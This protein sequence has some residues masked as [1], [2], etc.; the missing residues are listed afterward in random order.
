MY[1][2]SGFGIP[3]PAQSHVTDAL[4]YMAPPKFPTSHI[5]APAQMNATDAVVMALFHEL[6]QKH[7]FFSVFYCTKSAV[8]FP[9]IVSKRMRK[10][11]FYLLYEIKQSEVTKD[12]YLTC[13]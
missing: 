3:T 11:N 9:R 13:V 6:H 12:I 1:F 4:L 5:A 2:A 7:L 10:A 8:I